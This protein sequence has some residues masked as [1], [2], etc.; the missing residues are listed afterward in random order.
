ME[1]TF[2]VWHARENFLAVKNSVFESVK[3]TFDK[4]GISI[5]IPQISLHAGKGSKPFQMATTSG[6][7]ADMN[8]SD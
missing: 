6:E 2:A 5:A 7:I 3:E 1:L 4:E 8:E